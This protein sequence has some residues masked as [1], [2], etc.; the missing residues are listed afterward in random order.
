MDRSKWFLHPVAVFI[1][2]T[3]ALGL[4]L[5]L[6]IRWYIE[7]SAGLKALIDKFQIE[8]AQVLAPETWLVILTLSILVAIILIGIFIIFVYNQKALRLNRLQRTFINNFTHEL[9]TPVTS[10]KLFLETLSL[11]QLSREDQLKYIGYMLLDVERLAHTINRIL[12]LARI[13]SK[14]YVEAFEVL[15]LVQ[16][17]REFIESNRHLFRGSDIQIDNRCRHAPS[18]PLDR[19]LFEMLL[20][21]LINNA[22]T[23]N[24][25]PR[26][27]IDIIFEH[28]GGQTQV[29]FEDNGIGLEKGEI[30]K[31]F[32]KF[33]QIGG[34]ED[35]ISKGSG[36][37]LHLVQTIARL[38]GGRM[39]AESR[40]SGLGAAFTLLLPKRDSKMGRKGMRE[41][42][43]EEAYSDYRG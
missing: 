13:E 14:S 16:A 25:S 42:P 2:S 41:T 29:R 38:H 22:I 17:T 43:R 34:S 37:G 9:K 28:K 40:G 33:Y 23:Y 35:M 36:L 20:M 32:R 6:Y 21:N 27:L 26:P 30:K 1:F 24:E 12:T 39:M 10:L 11:H 7:A 31:I 8:P 15:D 4:S 18:Y 3:S 19:A 5:F